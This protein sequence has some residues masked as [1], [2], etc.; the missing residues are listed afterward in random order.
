V[1]PVPITLPPVLLPTVLQL[2]LLVELVTSREL[3]V[4]LV[5]HAL[6]L[7]MLIVLLLQP[8]QLSVKLSSLVVLIAMV[9]MWQ[10]LVM[11]DTSIS[12]PPIQPVLLVLLILRLVLLLLLVLSVKMVI[13]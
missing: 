4:L 2:L 10:P 12:Q 5:L 9:Q 13:S 7:R 6:V 11:K 1:L 3:Q 8:P